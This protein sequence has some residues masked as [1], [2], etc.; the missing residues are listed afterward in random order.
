MRLTF[1]IIFAIL[2]I[3]LCNCSYAAVRTHKPIGRY[4]ALLSVA[5]V[6]P[7]FGNMLIVSSGSQ[8]AALIGYYTYFI[9]MDA[10]MLCLVL[11][12]NAYCK[13]AVQGENV[14]HHSIPKPIYFLLAIDAVQMLL[15]P[16]FGHAF[17]TKQITVDG[18]AYHKIVPMAGQIFHRI[19]DYTIFLMVIAIFIAVTIRTTKI[20]RERYSV[21]LGAMA[22]IGLWETYYVFSGTPVDRS[23]IG[24][25]VFG[26]LIFYFALY[27]RPLRMF[28]RLLSDIVS[29][30]S[31]ALFVFEP[32]GKCIWANEKG[33]NIAQLTNNFFEPAVEKLN[34]IFGDL[35]GMQYKEVMEKAIG[36]DGEIRYFALDKHQLSQDK[37]RLSGSYLRIRD[38]TE[39]K[40]KIKDELYYSRHDRLTRLYTREYLYQRITELLSTVKRRD[41]LIIFVDVKNF[42]IVND[43]FGK[44]FGDHAL[45]HIADWGRDNLS[46]N[47]LYGRLVGDTFGICMPK[48]EFDKDY[49][50][51]QLSG[52]MVRYNK[53]E[54]HILVHFGVYNIDDS[55][56]D[57]SIMFDRA[58]MALSTIR[59]EYHTH[60]A[61]YDN[62]LRQ[63]MLWD[64]EISAQLSDAIVSRQLRPYLQPIADRSGRI[65]GA[66]ALVRWIHP[67]HG[68][69]APFRF[70]PIFETNGMIVELDKYMWRCAC[71]ILS[72]W[73][74]K[75]SGLF[76][77]VNISPK[78]LYFMDVVS[79]IKGLVREFG[80]DPSGLRI[81]I[82][83][84]IMMNDTDNVLNILNEFRRSGF[85]VEMDDFGSGYSSLNMLKD[86]PVDV[87]KIDMKFLSKSS[88]SGK[89]DTIVK[90]IINL[91]KELGI[92]SLTEGV[93]TQEQ[94][95]SLSD[96]GCKMFQ[97][98]Y[99]AKPMPVEEF[100]ELSESEK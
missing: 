20:Y 29:D 5:L 62:E 74:D 9:G 69:L 23:M 37:N 22:V 90:N 47:C 98:Y 78:D 60:I 94:Y 53:A 77:S 87:L 27:H 46:N 59:D 76:I 58:H 54:Y 38:I 28:D 1:S 70:V 57:V 18:Y 80:I 67:E 41:Y 26:L 8:L 39:E 25:A 16:I 84:T 40:D 81:E 86:M 10:A 42:K 6:P 32:S 56:T 15:N 11:F 72:R 92:D 73:K 82:T 35:S 66:E 7:V 48:S 36:M 13:G 61:F 12:S 44:E 55:D 30:M 91:S 85:I 93:E 24:F 4:V 50:E 88:N 89:A 96:M 65:V 19:V 3:A 51:A 71:E 43:I 52:V 64:Q 97:G 33:C 31:E 95:R 100:E 45:I 17:T 34:E 21:V 63:K 68:F 79:E 75:K 49:F 2:V 14:R 83:E 99:F